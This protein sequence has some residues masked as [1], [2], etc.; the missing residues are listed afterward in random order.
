MLCRGAEC[1]VEIFSVCSFERLFKEL[2]NTGVCLAPILEG[3]PANVPAVQV[4]GLPASCQGSDP[5]GIQTAGYGFAE[6]TLSA[7]VTLFDHAAPAPVI[8]S[9]GI[10]AFRRPLHE[11]GHQVGVPVHLEEAALERSLSSLFGQMR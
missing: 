5:Y 4:Q 9:A 3:R 6:G 7:Q 2:V 8:A 1:L 11:R 10:G